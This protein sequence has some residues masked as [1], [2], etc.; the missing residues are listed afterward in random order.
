MVIT[1]MA[2]SQTQKDYAWIGWYVAVIGIAIVLALVLI[3]V[4]NKVGVM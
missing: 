3:T 4:A 1:T 2:E